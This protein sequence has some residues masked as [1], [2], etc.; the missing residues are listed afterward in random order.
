[1]DIYEQWKEAKNEKRFFSGLHVLNEKNKI[2]VKE[3]SEI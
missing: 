1:M 2:R 3:E